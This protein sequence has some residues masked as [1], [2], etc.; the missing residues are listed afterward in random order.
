MTLKVLW[1]WGHLFLVRGREHLGHLGHLEHLG[2]L[3][4]LRFAGII[5]GNHWKSFFAGYFGELF[6]LQVIFVCEVISLRFTVF[7]L[8]PCAV[9][10]VCFVMCPMLVMFCLLGVY[11]LRTVYYQFAAWPVFHPISIA[12]FWSN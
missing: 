5:L 10:A 7:G 9:L 8:C 2:H 1:L 12:S 4:H 11:C 6:F 3:G